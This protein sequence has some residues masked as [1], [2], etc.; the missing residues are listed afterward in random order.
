MSPKPLYIPLTTLLHDL[1]EQ[2]FIIG[3]DTYQDI[4]TLLQKDDFDESP[5]KLNELKHK[6][7]SLLAN[8]PDEQKDFYRLFDK[9]FA[10]LSPLQAT[11][12]KKDAEEP[13]PEYPVDSS[14]RPHPKNRELPIDLLFFLSL[15]ISC[16]RY[17]NRPRLQPF[18]NEP[19]P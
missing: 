19:G 16:Y 8:N 18:L 11:E 17:H 6:L 13:Q 15:L 12:K 5:E 9:H 1:K 2:G 4:K 7:C 14:Q 3:V 10:E